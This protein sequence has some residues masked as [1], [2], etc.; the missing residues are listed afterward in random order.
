MLSVDQQRSEEIEELLSN[1]KSHS[2]VIETFSKK[3]S[4]RES[5]LEDQE[6]F[7]N[8]YKEQLTQY[9]EERN[10]LLAQ[11]QELIKS[12]KQ[13]LEY[14]TA[15]GLS[16]AFSE[17]YG[18][19]KSDKTASRWI[20]GATLFVIASMIIG[21]WV[22][23]EKD[24]S[25]EVV[26]GRVSL[27]PILLAGAW[28]C[29]GQYVKLKNIAEDY[30]YKSVLT[31]SIVGF[32]EQLSTKDGNGEE[33]SHYI[34]SV[35]EQIHNDPL[36]KHATKDAGYG[37]SADMKEAIKDIKGLQSAVDG[38]EKIVKGIKT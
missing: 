7:T 12:A 26:I 21:I 4:K 3:I 16:A 31:K 15:E 36:R 35:L 27:L 22:V 32:S 19:A 11:A 23:T 25:I 37:L 34:K 14:K 10:K 20:V 28:F 8:N 13:A 17:K 2:E 18:E 29:A 30:A 5:Q 24:I 38:I 1:S 9:S 6:V 33:Y